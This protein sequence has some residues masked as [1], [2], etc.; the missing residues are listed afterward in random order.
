[1]GGQVTGIRAILNA[2]NGDAGR[3]EEDIRKAIALG[4]GFGHSHHTAYSIGSAYAL[5]HRP[6]P[7]LEWLR[8]AA[9]DG[10][11]CYPL[12]EK[13][14]NLDNLRQDPGF[15]AFMAELKAQ[16][17]AMGGLVSLRAMASD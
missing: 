9:D 13:D 8:R 6:G 4:E 11:P 3:A 17:G 15:V 2:R 5:L 16:W 10:F 14:P 1:M 7:A 12:F